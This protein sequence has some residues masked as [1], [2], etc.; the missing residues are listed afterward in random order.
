[1]LIW[2]LGVNTLLVLFFANR[3]YRRIDLSKGSAFNWEGVG[4]SQWI[5]SLPLL[6]GPFIIFLPFNLLDYPEAGII[7]IGLIGLLF[8]VT[9]AYW[10]NKLIEQFQEKRYTIAQGFRNE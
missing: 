3:N 9:R 8:I 6:L 10:V 1:M 5:L 2:N 7:T 4:A